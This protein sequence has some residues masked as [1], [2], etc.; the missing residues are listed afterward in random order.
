MKNKMIVGGII[1]L[2]AAKSALGQDNVTNNQSLHYDQGDY[3]R[4]GELSV[5]VFGSG[6]LG[7]YTL[8]HPSA[9]RVRKNIRLGAG[10]G[11][12]YFRRLSLDAP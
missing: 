11:L 2:L 5:D 4:A 10:L 1:L 8:D 12:N 7:K 9:T 3:Y 6:S